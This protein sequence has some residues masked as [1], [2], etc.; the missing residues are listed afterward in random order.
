M[1]KSIIVEL[2]EQALMLILIISLPP[3]VITALVGILISLLLA[4]TQLQEQ[5]VTFLFKLTAVVV[6]LM[7]IGLWIGADLAQF[8]MYSFNLINRL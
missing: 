4:L 2:V 6:G 8:T 7:I 3:I 5:T 1:D